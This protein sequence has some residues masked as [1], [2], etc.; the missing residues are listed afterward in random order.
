MP[1][2][3]SPPALP[4][5]VSGGLAVLAGIVHAVERIAKVRL[6]W[7]GR[8]IKP[9]RLGPASSSDVPVSPDSSDD[10]PLTQRGRPSFTTLSEQ[11]PITRAEFDACVGAMREDI[12]ELKR[13]VHSVE[14]QVNRLEVEVARG[15]GGINTRLERLRGRLASIVESR[16]AQSR[17]SGR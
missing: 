1:D 3:E 8:R 9:K 15:V 2:L 14:H 11:S 17:R 16:G 7:R 6:D 12:A 10:G 4:L 5:I 13:D